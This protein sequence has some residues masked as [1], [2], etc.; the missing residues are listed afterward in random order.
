MTGEEAANI[1]TKYILD[2]WMA[3]GKSIK[4]VPNFK[5]ALDM[6]IKALKQEPVLS[7]IR[8][9]IEELPKTYPFVNHYDM[10]VKEDDIKK[11]INKYMTGEGVDFN[12]EADKNILCVIN[13]LPIV[14]LK[15]HLSMHFDPYKMRFVYLSLKEVPVS[16][17]IAACEAKGM[18]C[19]ITNNEITIKKEETQIVISPEG[20]VFI[21]DIPFSIDDQIKQDKN[22]KVIKNTKDMHQAITTLNALPPI[23]PQPKIGKWTVTDEKDELYSYVY[24]CSECSHS[25]IGGGNYCSY[26]GSKNVVGG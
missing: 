1:I 9:E 7:K 10:Y 12:K 22:K 4:D 18:L 14:H 25:V 21:N 5:I 26:C 11:I 16:E 8:A 6:A 24:I 13:G 2:I 19:D 15:G 3:D 17:F 23:L 20:K